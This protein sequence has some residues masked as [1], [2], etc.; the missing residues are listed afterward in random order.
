MGELSGPPVFFGAGD[1]A[2]AREDLVKVRVP[3]AAK[4]GEE[5]VAEAVARVAGIAVGGVLAPGEAFVAEPGFNLR[6]RDAE[7]G[8]DKAFGGDREDA[9]EALGSGAAQQAE[10]DSLGLV[11]LG[12]PGGDAVKVILLPHGGE[13]GAAGVAAAFLEAAGG[14][15]QIGALDGD[16]QVEA[17]GQLAD[18]GFVAV[19]FLAAQAVVQVEDFEIEPEAR[20]DFDEG[21]EEGGGVGSS[22]DGDTDAVAGSEHVITRDGFPDYF[23]HLS[24][25]CNSG[26][27]MPPSVSPEL[28]ARAARIRL[29]L[30]DVDGVLTDGKIF[31]LPKPDGG[32]WETKGFDSQ[33]GIA[34]QWLYRHGIQT[35]L[36]SGRKS[37]ATE[38]RGQQGHM[39]YVYQ[40]NTE[41]LPLYEEIKQKSGFRDDEIA[42]LGDDLT[43]G[44]LMKRVGFAVA[45]ANAKP[46]VKKIAHYVTE[47]PGGQGALREF[48]EIVLDAQGLWPAILRSYELEP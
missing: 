28:R 31:H 43:D 44:I 15:A 36:I 27:S 17:G 18:E 10:E 6:A 39:T 45:V 16:G 40:G 34:L 21:V 11:G 23:Q 41:K 8:A 30:M 29:I 13:E 9:A 12:V 46:E 33:D 22:A 3:V 32:F 4:L 47:V 20:G 38:I 19:R 1:F 24:L 48:A 26:V 5:I 37:E 42:Y 25:H 7:Q 2:E 35:G 14:V